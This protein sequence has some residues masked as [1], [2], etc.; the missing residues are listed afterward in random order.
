MGDADPVRRL[1]SSPLCAA[2][3][4]RRPSPNATVAFIVGLALAFFVSAARW[5]VVVLLVGVASGCLQAADGDGHRFAVVTVDGR[6]VEHGDDR[7]PSA[8]GRPLWSAGLSL[9]D[10][11]VS[12]LADREPKQ[13]PRLAVWDDV[14]EVHAGNR[15]VCEW[16]I[17]TLTG[18]E[19]LTWSAR[20]HE[21][22]RS[23]DLTVEDDAVAVDGAALAPGEN[24]TVRVNHTPERSNHTYEGELVFTYHGRWPADSLETV[25]EESEV[26]GHRGVVKTWP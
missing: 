17:L 23:F 9:E 7:D 11:R 18:D 10:R 4:D 20:L 2:V 6:I 13:A 14:I 16:P 19:A 15:T 5:L 1:R 12:L 26:T 24:R 8:C 3:G 21:L 22:D 25:A